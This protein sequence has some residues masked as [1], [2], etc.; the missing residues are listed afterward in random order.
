MSQL[1]G[2]LKNPSVFRE[3]RLW[4]QNWGEGI[5]PAFSSGG[6]AHLHDA[7]R[8]WRW[9]RELL[10][11]GTNT[12][13]PEVIDPGGRSVEIAPWK[14]TLPLPLSLPYQMFISISIRSN[15]RT[16]SFDHDLVT[17][18]HFNAIWFCAKWSKTEVN[19][20]WKDSE[21]TK[22]RLVTYQ[23]DEIKKYEN[24]NN[25]LLCANVVCFPDVT[26][27]CGCIFTAR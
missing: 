27:H 13:D 10:V 25:N 2:M 9:M 4:W 3:L 5:V 18:L 6:L 11:R 20:K 14:V 15:C 16:K 26:T 17:F 8:L 12:I 7:W 24:K 1:C 19:I 21:P 22:C 23:T